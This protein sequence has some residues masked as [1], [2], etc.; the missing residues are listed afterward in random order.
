MTHDALTAAA[1]ANRAHRLAQLAALRPLVAPAQARASELRGEVRR[2]KELGEGARFITQRIGQLSF[3]P[4]PHTLVARMIERA[5][6]GP[7]L[8]V[9][10]PSAGDGRIARAVHA[11]GVSIHFIQ[12]IELARGLVE[13][14]IAAGFATQQADFLEYEPGQLFDRVLMNP[15]FERGAD[16]AH[17]RHALTFLRPGGLLVAI[18]ANGPKQAQELQ[19]LADSWEPQP[20]GAFRNSGTNVSTVLLTITP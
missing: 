13:R 12:C 15:P 14:L 16:I 5:R 18:C 7:G 3:H 19:P 20:A 6:L 1:I 10:E 2:A 8:A 17:I 11:A 9:L 4:T